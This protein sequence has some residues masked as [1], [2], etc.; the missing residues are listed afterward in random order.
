MADIP[1]YGTNPLE[2][3]LQN[4]EMTCIPWDLVCSIWDVGPTKFVQMMI[5]GW[6]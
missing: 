2:N 5:L 3:H 1:I 6:P 4:L